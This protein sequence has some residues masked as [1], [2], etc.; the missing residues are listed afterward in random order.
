MKSL[1]RE[2][3]LSAMY[4]QAAAG[5]DSGNWKVAEIPRR[6][7][8]IEQ[9][10]DTVLLVTGTLESAGARSTD[11]ADPANHRRTVF[12]RIS[13]LKLNDLLLQFDYPD[14]N[15]H[16]EKRG[17]TT[18]AIQ[19]LFLLN[20]PFMLE[21]ARQLTERLHRE[22]GGE[23]AARVMRAYQLLFNGPADA[24]EVQ[25]A[26]EFLQRP[27][28]G[29]LTRWQQYAQLLLVSNEFL[30]RLIWVGFRRIFG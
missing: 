11:L 16:A 25:L 7:M 5:G 22:A 24:V 8:S 17:A 29:E 15:V 4:R 30:C 19:K 12:A 6:R 9:W 26:R 13:R 20:S 21:R 3:A 18:T 14:A 10:R 2:L 27:A 1:V 28:T 23:D